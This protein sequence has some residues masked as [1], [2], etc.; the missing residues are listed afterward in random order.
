MSLGWYNVYS[1]VY[2]LYWDSIKTEAAIKNPDF[3]K[4]YFKFKPPN[5]FKI[6]R[7]GFMLDENTLVP[8]HRYSEK[9]RIE[10][11]ASSKNLL[12]H[13]VQIDDYKGVHYNTSGNKLVIVYEDNKE[14]EF[15][16]DSI[17]GFVTFQNNSPKLYRV[18]PKGLNWYG[19]PG[20]MVAQIDQF[21]IYTVGEGRTYSYF[22]RDLNS[23]ILPLNFKELK[24]EFK[25]KPDFVEKVY[26]EFGENKPL[27]SLDRQSNSY[28]VIELYNSCIKKK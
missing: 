23:K 18:T 10:L 2:T 17:W 15:H 11:F 8:L 21:I 19:F 22:S 6:L 5:V 16:R 4:R 7:A 13:N 26:E 20:V 3:Y 25:D 14:Q 28:R 27:N 24:K 9:D 12:K 1:G